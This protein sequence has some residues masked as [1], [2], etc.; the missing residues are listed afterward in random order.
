MLVWSSGWLVI[1]AYMLYYGE[2]NTEA[3]GGAI[4]YHRDTNPVWF[5]G[6]AVV[7]LSM[8]V[9][10]LALTFEFTKQHDDANE[11]TE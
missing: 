5:W 3:A 4:T 8:T 6:T 9:L 1:L 11:D 7:T 2:I 10:G